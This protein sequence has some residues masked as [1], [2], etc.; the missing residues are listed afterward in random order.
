MKIIFRTDASS[1]IGTGHVMRCLTLAEQLRNAGASVTFIC[2]ELKGD[3]IHLIKKKNFSVY[4]LPYSGA[5]HVGESPDHPHVHWLRTDWRVDSKQTK[6]YLN[7][8]QPIDWL[9][10]DHYA[11][12]AK[13]EEQMKSSV[14]KI[15]VID[16]LADR[17]HVCDILLDQNLYKNMENRYTGLVPESSLSLLGPSYILFRPEFRKARSRLHNRKGK[18]KRVLIAFGGSDPTNETIKAMN[19]LKHLHTI[20]FYVDV[21]VGETNLKKKKIKDMCEGFPNITY[22]CQIDYMADLMLRADLALGGGGSTT[23]ERC[24]LGLPAVTIEMAVN[25]SEILI[26]LADKGAICHL[27]KSENV[28]ESEIAKCL[29]RLLKNPSEIKRM[30]EAALALISNHKEGAV[31]RHIMEG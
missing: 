11:I 18:V 30:A 17:P 10:I 26:L 13:W 22:H 31:I 6:E 5:A 21:V 20:D 29:E 19:A 15:M 7:N 14:R 12:D 3:L 16:D 9:I 1:E 4:V 2:R 27:G 28:G 23:W 8:E 24:Y 25:Q